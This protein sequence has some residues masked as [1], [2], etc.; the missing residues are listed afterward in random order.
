M[1]LIFF[2]HDSGLYGASLSFVDLVWGLKQK[3]IEEIFFIPESGEIEILLREKNINYEIA[4]YKS[5]VHGTLKS[6][7]FV[8]YLRNLKFRMQKA[9]INLKTVLLLKKRFKNQDIDYIYTNTVTIPVGIWLAKLLKIKH[10]W[11]IRE[12]GEPDHGFRFDFGKAIFS[13]WLRRST[14]VIYISKALENYYVQ[15]FT[16]STSTVVYNGVFTK[17]ILKTLGSEKTYFQNNNVRFLMLGQIKESKGH[18][19][20]IESFKLILKEYPE[21]KLIIVG[22]GTSDDI[23]KI[24][25]QV[26]HVP[27]IIL[28]PFS[29]NVDEYYN[30]SDVLLMC[31]SSEAFGRVTIEA[32]TYGLTVIGNNSGATP[33][34]IEHERNGLLYNGSVE[35]L[36]N[37]MKLLLTDQMWIKKIGYEAKKS[38]L[39]KYT[40]DDYINSIYELLD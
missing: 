38:V 34:I 27:N 17:E 35:D 21:S 25:Q 7:S 9:L 20:A 1:K 23:E 10:V 37:F 3:G 19:I 12:F 28:K 2:A 6:G 26:N 8:Y 5:W 32:M 14:K 36:F 18:F 15:N 4:P 33:E 39:K 40:L 22:S 31:S 30:S 29:R 13:F 24:N 11:H 16:K